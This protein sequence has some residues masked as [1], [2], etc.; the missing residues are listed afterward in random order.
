M[1][2]HHTILTSKFWLQYCF[3]NT[4]LFII[5]I[6]VSIPEFLG[7]IILSFLAN[8][9]CLFFNI[10]FSNFYKNILLSTSKGSGIKSSFQFLRNIS[11]VVLIN[12]LLFI[13]GLH[14]ILYIWDPEG[15]VVMFTSN[16]IFIKRLWLS[17]IGSCISAFYILYLY[18]VNK[19]H[20]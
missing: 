18:T 14:T 7:I 19:K 20:I 1:N 16:F 10:F 12:I 13:I 3:T 8:I 5:I 9:I 2:S 11:F 15:S 4:I 17:L 6:V